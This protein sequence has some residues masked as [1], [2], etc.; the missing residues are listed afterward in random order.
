MP[1]PPKQ[2]KPDSDDSSDPKP[3]LD[4]HRVRS[5]AKYSGMAFQMGI[6]ILAG[7]LFGQWLD[8]KLQTGPYLT[9]FLALFSIFAALYVA[10]KDFIS[11]SKKKED[12]Q[13]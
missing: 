8:E 11:P 6:I 1:Q 7:T 4:P 9:I 2:H 5:Y 3:I 13:K 10:L 12:D